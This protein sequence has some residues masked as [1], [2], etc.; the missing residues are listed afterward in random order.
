MLL[1]GSLDFLSFQGKM[2]TMSSLIDFDA[3]TAPSP[4]YSEVG[5]QK[6]SGSTYTP[7]DFAAFVA[8]QIVQAA[9]LPKSGKIRVLDPACGDGALL[10]AL[11]KRLSPPARK[12][13][14]VV[15]Y[16]T[17]HYAIR[18]ATQRLR[19]DFPEL[20]IRLE[21]KD[22]LDH[23]LNL[24]GGGDLF[25][26]GEVQEPFHLVIANPPYVRTQI[27]GA[28]QARQIAQRFGLSGRVDL[29]HPF[30]LAISQVLAKNGVAGVITSNR[31][32]TTRSGQAIRRAMLTR[33]HIL[34]VWDLGDTK[35][36]D[37]AVLPSLLLARGTSESQ[38]PHFDGITYS[39]IYET[40]D[41]AIAEATDA[42]SALTADNDTVIAIQD[43]R[44]FRVRHGTLDSGGDPEGIWRVATKA[45]DQWLA[46]VEANTWDTFRRIGKIRVGVKS[47]ADKV[48]I[49]N[50]WDDLPGGRPELLRPLIT[51]KFARRFKAVVPTKAEHIKEILYPH[52]A[53]K[54]GR[55]AVD[56]QLYPKAASYLERHRE[57]LE[58]RSYLI[59][60]G[61]KW[62]ELW[63]PQDPAAW[64]SPK[65]VF[66]DITDKP[67]FWIDMEGGIVNGECYWLQC[68]NIDEQDL[69][70][71]AL[72]VANSTFIEAFYDHRF[73]NKLY[74]GRRRFITQYVELFPLPNPACDEAIAIIA[75]AKEIYAKTPSTEADQ[76][77]TNLDAL[78]WRAFGL[79]V[80]KV[81]G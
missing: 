37:A 48:F 62:Y 32:M 78:I 25:S 29:Y 8:D 22:F 61:R 70:W 68:E 17:D 79:H 45:T 47:T 60:A 55:A 30:L 58:A 31:F 27:M 4:R 1:E 16:D 74:A 54:D 36:F 12:R 39:S 59:E 67:I 63:V 69:L 11:V 51:R 50:D 49:R 75:L 15:G 81:S 18:I 10:D 52:D 9:D 72:A 26:A 13:V 77:A 64:A 20:N 7:V 38:Q 73:N 6:S 80:E 23:V 46:T 33:F 14:E 65:L 3:G 43:G 57:V 19:H 76:L 44:H 35:L 2:K 56:L 21:Q 24:Q 28:Q 53:T 40:K 42:L 5:Q 71:L 41:A 34:H 66:P